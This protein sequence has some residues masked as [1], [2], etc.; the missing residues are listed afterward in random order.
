MEPAGVK[1]EAG[2]GDDL[3]MSAEIVDHS[4]DVPWSAGQIDLRELGVKSRIFSNSCRCNVVWMSV[5]RIWKEHHVRMFRAK[6]GGNGVSGRDVV[7]YESV[8]ES[9]AES[10]SAQYF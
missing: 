7:L 9:Y 6:K 8:L 4:G 10:L 2:L 5:I 3:Q 1:D